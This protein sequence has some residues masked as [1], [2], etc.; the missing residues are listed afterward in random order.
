ML[1][2]SVRIAHVTGP[3]ISDL[4]RSIQRF[5]KHRTSEEVAAELLQDNGMLLSRRQFVQGLAMG[6]AVASF[7]IASK[8]VFAAAI[9]Q[10]QPD[11]LSGTQFNLTIGEQAV[12]FTGAPRIATT[13]NGSLPAPILH[14]KEGDTVTINVHN[15]L[16]E[17]S[18]IH[19]H[20]LILPSA[21]DGVPGIATGFKGIRSGESFTYQF[22]IVQ[23]GTYWYHSHSGFQEQTGL[24]GPIIIDPKEPEPFDYDRDYVVMFSDWTDEDP[25]GVYAKLKKLSHYYNFN[26]RT[27]ADLMRDINEKGL[28][29]TWRDRQMW[30]QMRMSQRDLSDVTGYTY[31]FLTNGQTP[32]DGWTGLF[33]KGEKIR[34][35]FINGSAMTFFDVRIPGLNMT[36]VSADGQHI[37]PV[38]VDEFRIGVAE[39]FDVIVEPSD[40]Q[41]YTIF[42]Q[43]IARSGYARGTLTP[44]LNMRGEIP[45]MDAVPN[46]THDDMGMNHG[47]HEMSHEMHQMP[48]GEMMGGMDHSQH[49]M[50]AMQ[51]MDHSQ[52]QMPAMQGMDHSQHQMPAM[53]GM[54]HS[55][56]QMSAMQH[57]NHDQ[58][59]IPPNPSDFTAVPVKHADT[60]Y[61]PH[62]D[63]RAD[64]PQYRLD[65]PG[66]G[67]RDNGRRVLTYADL[68]NLRSTY[69]HR[70]PDREIELHLTGNMGRYM[71]SINGV[72]HSDAEPLQWKLGERLRITLVNDTMMNHPMHL[73]GMWS[74]LE[75]GD[76]NYLPRKH[77]VVVQPGS[78]ISYRV[79]VDAEG[80]WAYHCHLLYHML[81]MFRTVVVS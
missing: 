34:L 20:G 69:D 33:K 47:A 46:L 2:K 52:H 60:E 59:Q 11:I 5:M 50:P 54:D 21:M 24:Y 43:D 78:R 37:E 62:V 19:W 8:S 68:R 44:D 81:G 14:W 61:G 58:Q 45:E 51:G 71:W 13:V 36:V 70:E 27:H 29:A 12:N 73:H 79:T 31:T 75:T 6:G 32:T 22:P 35:R 53:Q 63:M 55:Q 3:F 39:T 23:S 18:S 4:H 65:D 9:Q 66:V 38:S 17:T 25:T 26:E 42:A 15:Q 77:T 41:A 49:Q 57:M 16:D 1:S 30:N 48:S 80:G 67:L 56:H 40:E 72:K 10:Q 28:E 64:L 74:D 7:G 76:N